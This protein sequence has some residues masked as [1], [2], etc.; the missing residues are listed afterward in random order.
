MGAVGEA[1]DGFTRA[2]LQQLLVPHWHAESFSLAV[3]ALGPTGSLFPRGPDAQLQLNW[4]QQSQAGFRTCASDSGDSFS[5]CLETAVCL[6][7][8]D[9]LVASVS[10][11]SN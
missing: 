6:V 2:N 11:Y 9:R 4:A 1:I 5:W 8:W 3:T 10:R 7:P